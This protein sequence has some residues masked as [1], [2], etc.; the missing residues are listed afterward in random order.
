MSQEQI[1][2]IKNVFSTRLEILSHI[3]ERSITHFQAD[4]ESIIGDRIVEDMLPFGTQ[5]IFTCNQPHNFSLWCEGKGMQNLP[6][7]VSSLEQLKKTIE[8][9]QLKINSVNCGDGQLP[10]ISRIDLNENQYMELTGDE[11]VNDFLIPNF[12]F[13]LV[14]AYN[15]MRMKGVPL[16]KGDYMLH[17][18]PKVRHSE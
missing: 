16:G 11:Y 13:H 17:L 6:S 7:E 5:V 10:E 1:E 18:V 3:L 14:T 12:Y 9:T 15:I 8:E 2:F 4:S